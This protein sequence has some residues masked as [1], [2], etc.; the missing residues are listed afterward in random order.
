MPILVNMIAGSNIH[1]NSPN[2]RFMTSEKLHACGK[3]MHVVPSYSRV[4]PS[5]LLKG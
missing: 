4:V 1:N 5:A 3:Q 2:Y